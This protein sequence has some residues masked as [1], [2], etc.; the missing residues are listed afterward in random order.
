MS[1]NQYK[2]EFQSALPKYAI[3]RALELIEFSDSLVRGL[4]RNGF[5]VL[6]STHIQELID[7]GPNSAEGWKILNQM[8]VKFDTVG[9]KAT[10]P[11]LEK[12]LFCMIMLVAHHAVHAILAE[13][14]EE[15]SWHHGR[16]QYLI[17]ATDFLVWGGDDAV[18]MAAKGRDGARVTNSVYDSTKL[19]VLAW[20]DL[21][22]NEYRSA[23]AAAREINKKFGVSIDTAKKYLK[24][25]S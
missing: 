7:S 15:S 13:T 11:E 24:E 5:P 20:C 16:G 23:E 18:V 17:G 12:M 6:P 2:Y 8:K 25:T 14:E 9:Y 21:H 1:K 22:R 19:E 3:E 4:Q 10:R